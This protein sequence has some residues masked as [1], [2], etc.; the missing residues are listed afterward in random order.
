MSDLQTGRQ[1]QV[2][3][4]RMQRPHDEFEETRFSSAVGPGDADAVPLVQGEIGVLEKNPC[5]PSQ[6]D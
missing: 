6:G 3:G 4:I 1:S 2:S 5:S